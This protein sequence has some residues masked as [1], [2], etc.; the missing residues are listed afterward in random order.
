MFDDLFVLVN[1][2]LFLKLDH[3]TMLGSKLRSE[4]AATTSSPSSPIR[5]RRGEIVFEPPSR[6]A[7]TT[8]RLNAALLK[9][10]SKEIPPA[11]L[12]TIHPRSASPSKRA[13]ITPQTSQLFVGKG[14]VSGLT[15]RPTSRTRSASA[16]HSAIVDHLEGS[17]ASLREGVPAP[18]DGCRR[19]VEARSS[20]QHY[21]I[22][23]LSFG[24]A[25]SADRTTRTG[26]RKCSADLTP[27]RGFGCF[28][29]DPNEVKER[30]VPPLMIKKP[31]RRGV[32]RVPEPAS[33]R[34][35]D[36][37]YRYSRIAENG[38]YLHGKRQVQPKH[39]EPK[40]SSIRSN[41][42]PLDNMQFY[43]VESPARSRSTGI[44]CG[45]PNSRP[46]E[47]NIINH[48]LTVHAS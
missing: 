28:G 32:R 11:G 25:S 8:P 16:T 22:G 15:E 21:S 41:I 44:R 19:H 13:Q 7:V 10:A 4:L 47:Y 37:D 24:R 31:L 20:Q 42:A 17:S 38:V 43:V 48:Q 1:I 6:N 30:L 23:D 2:Y 33:A 40:P 18:F 39:F 26:L 46:R 3:W 9:E 5:S 12:P 45:S 29:P 36:N 14:G 35:R 34:Y 27:Y